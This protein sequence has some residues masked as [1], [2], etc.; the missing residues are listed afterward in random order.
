MG[1]G[2]T[3]A[4]AGC[5]SRPLFVEAK[6]C[7]KHTLLL[8]LR[9]P[10][11]TIEGGGEKGGVFIEKSSLS[12]MTSS[13]KDFYM[14]EGEILSNKYN[15]FTKGSATILMSPTPPPPPPPP[16]PPTCRLLQGGES[17]INFP[18]SLLSLST[19]TF[20]CSRSR[21]GDFFSP[22]N[23]PH[24]SVSLSSPLCENCHSVQW[25]LSPPNSFTK[26][27]PS[28]ACLSGGICVPSQ[29]RKRHI[30]K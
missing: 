10:L 25:K 3:A 1:T 30:Q 19:R 5:L 13:A 28:L 18:L 26:T 12:I 22:Q 17:E 4:L 27:D 21:V 8:L 14:K 29:R 2:K 24:T 7:G 6:N 9:S 11:T 16:P 15:S 20:A 23:S